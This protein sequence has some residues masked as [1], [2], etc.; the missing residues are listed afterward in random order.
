[1]KKPIYF[2]KETQSHAASDQR[3]RRLVAGPGPSSAC[4]AAQHFPRPRRGTLTT[5]T[6]R[7]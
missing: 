6:G 7:E 4:C 5:K 1:M 2:A 3:V